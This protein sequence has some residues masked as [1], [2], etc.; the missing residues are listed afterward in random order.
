MTNGPAPERSGTSAMSGRAEESRPESS[1]EIR[2][3]AGFIPPRR[4]YSG[5][6]GLVFQAEKKVAG[7]FFM[8]FFSRNFT[9]LNLYAALGF[10]AVFFL[11]RKYAW[12]HRRGGAAEATRSHLPP[13][14]RIRGSV[15]AMNAE[16]DVLVEESRTLASANSEGSTFLTFWRRCKE[17][18]LSGSGRFGRNRETEYTDPLVLFYKANSSASTDM[19]RIISRLEK[20]NGYLDMLKTYAFRITLLL[21]DLGF[22]IP[23]EESAGSDPL[24]ETIMDY[25]AITVHG[26]GKESAGIAAFETAKKAEELEAA[27]RKEDIAFLRENTPVFLEYM[28]YFITGIVKLT[29]E[30]NI[31]NGRRLHAKRGTPS[32]PRRFG[33]QRKKPR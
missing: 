26:I 29:D 21:R 9:G 5:L 8:D 28:E 18:P 33:K 32:I 16:G 30:K 14:N 11:R 13:K 4:T 27:A 12:N 23:S 10:M 17:L 19:A 2:Q 25:Y 15:F 7:R 24:V 3:I 31:F 6:P 22:Q 1:N 20:E